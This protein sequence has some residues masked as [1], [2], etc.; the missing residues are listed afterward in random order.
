M[1]KYMEIAWRQNEIYLLPIGFPTTG[2]AGK[3]SNISLSGRVVVLLISLKDLV[4][5]ECLNRWW[6]AIVPQTQGYLSMV[7]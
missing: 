4:V 3:N 2:F 1:G 7:N 5:A 6:K